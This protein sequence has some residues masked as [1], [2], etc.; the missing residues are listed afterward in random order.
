MTIILPNKTLVDAFYSYNRLVSTKY[1]FVSLISLS[2]LNTYTKYLIDDIISQYL[3]WCDTTN[4]AYNFE[5]ELREKAHV[6]NSSNTSDSYLLDNKLNTFFDLYDEQI[7]AILTEHIRQYIEQI[8][9]NSVP[10]LIILADGTAL[11]K[12]S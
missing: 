2:D 6:L 10:E 3:E 4:R 11:I 9:R 12:H 8:G 5:L 1:Q 7:T